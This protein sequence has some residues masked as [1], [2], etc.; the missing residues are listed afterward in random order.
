[1]WVSVATRRCHRRGGRR[2]PG[3]FGHELKLYRLSWNAVQLRQLEA[4]LGGVIARG[5]LV[6]NEVGGERRR[7]VHT[8]WGLRKW[9]TRW[10]RGWWT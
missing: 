4:Q 2:Y 3:S 1:M 5:A 9:R 6:E 10:R 7:P 8:H